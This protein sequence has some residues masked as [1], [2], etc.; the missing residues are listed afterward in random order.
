MPDPDRRA[1]YTDTEGPNTHAIAQGLVWLGEQTDAMGAA[2]G[3]LAVNTLDALTGVITEAIGELAARRLGKGEIVRIGKARIR[4]YTR[5]TLP[6]FRGAAA[7]LVLHPAAELLDKVDGLSGVKAVAVIPWL[8]SEV[9]AWIQT[10]RATDLS[11]KPP[12]DA[13]E[14]LSPVFRAA[15]HD[16]TAIVNLGTGITHPSDHDTAV[17]TF[18]T[19][20]RA[21]ESLDAVALKAWLQRNKWSPDSAN[22]VVDLAERVFAGRAVRTRNREF[23]AERMLQR[24]R[25]MAAEEAEQG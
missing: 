18:L 2:E 19:L 24:W 14:R 17:H 10:W 20:S 8:R 11:G 22:A 23:A 13:P 4:C 1:L 3:W 16:L 15:M 6:A 12:A 7:M 5:R 21:G 25:E 9:A